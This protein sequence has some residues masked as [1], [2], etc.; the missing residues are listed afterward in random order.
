MTA[1]GFY[2]YDLW[3]KLDTVIDLYEQSRD[4]Y[5]NES[6]TES[7]YGHANSIYEQAESFAKAV[8][9][10]AEEL[11]SP[12]REEADLRRLEQELQRVK[13][14]AGYFL[15]CANRIWKSNKP[16]EEKI[17]LISELAKEH[18]PDPEDE[19]SPL[20]MVWER[21]SI[22]LAWEAIDR[23]KQGPQRILDLYLLALG[24]RPS[25]RVQQF[26]TR[27]GRCYSW[28]FEPECV[29]LCRSVIDA[30]FGDTVDNA[31]CEKHPRESGKIGFTL[32]DKIRAAYEE[33]LI[34]RRTQ[35]AAER[36]R[37]RGNQ[38]V[39]RQPDLTKDVLGT[40][41]DTLAVLE[42]LSTRR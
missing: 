19:E 8:L 5:W 9:T 39:H 20:K 26:L 35:K 14:F 2:D 21:L 25:P 36:I 24:T 17:K 32:A 22:D 15:E 27:L 1:R 33:G 11:M 34:D 42:K 7:E 28:G 12:D 40:V 10:G 31:M 13:R 4:E 18:P 3:I 41:R 29:M 37:L 23:I 16:E 38:A 6:V 30:A